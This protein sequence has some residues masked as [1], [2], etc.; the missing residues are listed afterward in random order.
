MNIVKC[1]ICGKTTD[2]DQYVED[3]KKE[4][5]DNQLCFK[6]NHW[7]MNHELDLD[8]K[9]RGEHKWAV[10]N[11]HHYVIAPPANSNVMFAGFG[12]S[13]FKIKFQDGTIVETSNLW[14]QGDIK[15]AHPHWREL[16]PDNA[17]FVKDEGYSWCG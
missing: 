3:T 13:K 5:V 8:P 14:H 16:M 2:V 4:L 15:E 17:K 11:G 1:K 7:R 9:V 10:I 6:C 12:G